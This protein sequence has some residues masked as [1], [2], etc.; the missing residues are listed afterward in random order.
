MRLRAVLAAVL[1]ALVCLTGV[2][3]AAAEAEAAKKRSAAVKKRTRVAKK[4]RLKAF[5]SCAQVVRYGRRNV[6][7]GQGAEPPPPTVL[8]RPTPPPMGVPGGTGGPGAGAEGSPQSGTPAPVVQEDSSTTN[9]Q[10][11]G[12][13]EPDVVK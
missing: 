8:I 10:E 6:S 1:A 7:R 5:R 13:D 12:I 11:Q 2:S 9:V 4:T 3:V